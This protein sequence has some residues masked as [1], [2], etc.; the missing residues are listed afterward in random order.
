MKVLKILVIVIC[1]GVLSCKEETPEKKVVSEI[2]TEIRNDI[3]RVEP[4]N[5]WI[6]FKNQSVQLLETQH[7]K[8]LIKVFL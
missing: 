8:F 7:Q 3:Q 1:F 4:P 5:W 2:V 6:G